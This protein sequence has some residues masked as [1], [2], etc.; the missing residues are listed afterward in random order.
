MTI[1]V[2]TFPVASLEVTNEHTR[3][4]KQYLGA[5]TCPESLQGTGNPLLKL[6]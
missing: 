2:T 3:N 6:L 5:V 1:A 4:P